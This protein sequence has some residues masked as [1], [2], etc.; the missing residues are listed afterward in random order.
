MMPSKV[1]I[2]VVGV[3]A[4]PGDAAYDGSAARTL[5][6][7]AVGEARTMVDGGI[8]ALMVQNISALPT[9]QRATALTIAWMTRIASEIRYKVCVPLGINCLEDDAESILS[10]ADAVEAEFVRLKVYVGVMVG[11]DGLRQGVAHQAQTFRRQLASRPA[12]YAD[13]YD[14]TRTPL[15]RQTLAEMVHEATWFGKADGLVLTG[16][17]QAETEEFLT[18]GRQ[19]TTV[20]L[21]VGGGVTPDTIG[22]FLTLADGAIVATYLKRDGQL[23]SPVD[24]ERVRKLMDAARAARQGDHP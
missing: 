22:R 1:V 9:G 5:V 7:Q 16:R 4:L 24:P 3:R 2:G 11:P 19:H 13:V 23:L 18:V 8:D 21:L 6:E 17:T 20:P 10:V 12:I 14:R 15:G